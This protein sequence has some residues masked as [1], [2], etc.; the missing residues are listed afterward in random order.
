[1]NNLAHVLGELGRLADAESAARAAVALGGTSL[2][3]AR[4]TL[5]AILARRQQP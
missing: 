4:N 3:E 2:P 1:L 5:E